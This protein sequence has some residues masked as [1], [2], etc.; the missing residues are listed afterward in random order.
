MARGGGG[1]IDRGLGGSWGEQV[2]GA[3]GGL[4]SV[5]CIILYFSPGALHVNLLATLCTEIKST[6]IKSFNLSPTFKPGFFR[7]LERNC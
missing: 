5:N 1:W 6:N 2:G 4:G 7:I 3:G